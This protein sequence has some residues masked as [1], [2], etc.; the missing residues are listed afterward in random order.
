MTVSDNT[1]KAEGLGDFFKKLDRKELKMSKR[2]AK[3]HFKQSNQSSRYHS[4][5]CCSSK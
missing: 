3:K 1:I 5:Y 2:M 4:K